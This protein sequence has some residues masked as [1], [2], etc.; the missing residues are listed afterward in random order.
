M[1]GQCNG[2]PYLGVR[3]LFNADLQVVGQCED[4]SD[5]LV[6]SNKLIVYLGESALKNE[7]RALY[8]ACDNAVAG[9][10]TQERTDLDMLSRV[11]GRPA[12]GAV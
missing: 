3:A 10:D 11:L 1:C 5:W 6:F 9:L 7:D 8:R 2:E 4:R 12:L